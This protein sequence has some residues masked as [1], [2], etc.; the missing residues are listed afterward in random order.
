MADNDKT[1]NGSSKNGRARNRLA[2]V[3]LGLSVLAIV[4]LALAVIIQDPTKSE[5]VFHVVL[6][7]FASWVGTIL[8]FYFGRDSFESANQQVREMVRQLTPEQRAKKPVTS[9]MKPLG[10]I[11][12]FQI[13]S[14]KEDKDVKLS[15]LKARL[16]G[17]VTRLPIIDAEKKPKYMIH[18]SSIDKY[19][20]AGGKE[21]DTLE[22]FITTQKGKGVTFGLDKGFVVVS[23]DKTLAAAK[24]KMEEAHSC[25]DI[26]VTK[27]GTP[28]EPLTGWISNVRLAKYL[29][30]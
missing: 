23:E 15:E 20:V 13:P 4:G 8:V 1:S 17:S 10:T 24:S 9:I 18:E 26:F 22:D 7:V 30:G 16:A 27:G 21:G 3:I 12:Y 5:N 29:E 6:P 11:A 2:F 19:L 14:G 25:Q 28:T